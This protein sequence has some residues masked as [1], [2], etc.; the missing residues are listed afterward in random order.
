MF[1]PFE[2]LPPHSRLWIY[3][4]DRKFTTTEKDT[5]SSRLKAFVE[6]W[7]AHG[8]PM[9]ASFDIRYDQFILLAADE[10][11]CMASGCSIDSSVAA[12]KEAGSAV[13]VNLFD[14]SKV[15]FRIQDETLLIPL[16]ELSEK[17]TGGSWTEH[18]LVFNNLVPRKADLENQWLV[19]AAATWLRR[20]VPRET[21]ST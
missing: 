15:A 17:Y 14:R 16:S 3:Q 6:E 4:G 20:Y 5:I 21:M 11:V 7:S 1:T 18:S 10:N 8:Q 2:S 19:P 9:Q 13:G 12:I